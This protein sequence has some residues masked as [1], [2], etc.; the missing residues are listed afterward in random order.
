MKN[1][2]KQGGITKGIV[3]DLPYK[4]K[5]MYVFT[6]TPLHTT[7][8]D[9]TFVFSMPEFLSIISQDP[10]IK[11]YGSLAAQSLYNHSKNMI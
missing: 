1:A 9:V 5:H 2:L 6:R 4:G 10:T 3:P 7:R 8:T 11:K